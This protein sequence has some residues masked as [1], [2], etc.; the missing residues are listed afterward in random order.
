MKVSDKVVSNVESTKNY[1]FMSIMKEMK[2]TAQEKK[3]PSCSETHI[4]G[5]AVNHLVISV[6]TRFTS[7][8]SGMFTNYP[9]L[10]SYATSHT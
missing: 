8:C 10:H 3:S 5:A 9:I 6:R 2:F 7:V 4:A 1:E